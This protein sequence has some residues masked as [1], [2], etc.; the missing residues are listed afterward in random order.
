MRHTRHVALLIQG[1][2]TTEQQQRQDVPDAHCHCTPE[3]GLGLP[4]NTEVM[5]RM[6]VDLPQPAETYHQYRRLH[7]YDIQMLAAIV[8]CL[9]LRPDQL[10]LSWQQP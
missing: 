5:R 4:P 2:A 10:L 6:N 7:M 3:G 1:K 8:T 9:S